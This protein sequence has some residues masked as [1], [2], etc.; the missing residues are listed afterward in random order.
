MK[1]DNQ[2]Q[3]FRLV[4][5]YYQTRVLVFLICYLLI[6]AFFMAT[7]IFLPNFLQLTDPRQSFEVQAAAAEKILSGHKG[8]WP[9]LLTLILLISIHF[10]IVFHRFIGPMYRFSDAFRRIG[11]GDLR[12]PV[13]LRKRD[14]LTEERDEI[15][16]LMA[17]LAE[18]IAEIR[19]S[20]AET[21]LAIEKL[22]QALNGQSATPTSTQDHLAHL[23]ALNQRLNDHLDFFK[24]KKASSFPDP[25]S[26]D[27]F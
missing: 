25:G 14:F 23:R 9:S 21:E 1:T 10:Y 6:V 16:H 20:Q 5:K 22:A 15:N 27:S 11:A 4:H 8:M 19:H 24:L 17:A 2:R 13:E 18:R 7:F 26:E 12:Y 3:R